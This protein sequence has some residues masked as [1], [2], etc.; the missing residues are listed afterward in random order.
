[1]QKN[2]EIDK[3][4]QNYQA[5]L[6][7]SKNHNIE[8]CMNSISYLEEQETTFWSNVLTFVENAKNEVDNIKNDYRNSQEYADQL[9]QIL[10]SKSIPVDINEHVLTIGPLTIEVILEEYKIMLCMGRKKVKIS[11]LEINK[12]VKFIELYYKKINNSFNAN[13]FVTRLIKAYEYLNRALY[14]SQKTQFGNAVPL[15]DIFKMFTISP[16]SSDYKMENFLWDLGRLI[17]SDFQHSN[18]LIEFGTSRKISRTLIIK[19]V[20]GNEN[21]FSTL[22]I[23]LKDKSTNE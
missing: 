21:K 10:M 2:K 8:L 20:D 11:D 3:F 6:N 19:D 17:S 7:A 16:A 22:T 23:Y 15:E 12:V 1:M 13:S 14:S 9:Y 18:Y 4:F 5:F